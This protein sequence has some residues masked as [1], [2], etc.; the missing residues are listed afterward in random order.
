MKSD[1]N[2]GT[3]AKDQR[4]KLV[5]AFGATCTDEKIKHLQAIA[6]AKHYPILF[7]PFDYLNIVTTAL[8]NSG[9]YTGNGFQKKQMTEKSLGDLSKSECEDRLKR[10]CAYLNVEYAPERMFS[11]VEDGGFH[12][13]PEVWRAVAAN[14]EFLQECPPDVLK[15]IREPAKP[16]DKDKGPGAETA[17]VLSAVLGST[18]LMH[19]VEKA[20]KDIKAKNEGKIPPEYLEGMENT[21]LN[22]TNILDPTIDKSSSAKIPYRLN[23]TEEGLIP[24]PTLSDNSVPYAN[25]RYM[26]AAGGKH[27]TLP[28]T[29][30]DSKFLTGFQSRAIALEEIWNKLKTKIKSGYNFDRPKRNLPLHVRVLGDDQSAIRLPNETIKSKWESL[31]SPLAETADL[32]NPVTL[33]NGIQPLL[34]ASDA[35]IVMPTATSSNLADRFR[36]NFYLDSITV[37]KQTEPLCYQ[38]PV[39][40]VDDGSWSDALEFH[41]KLCEVGFCKDYVLPWKPSQLIGELDS[42][43]SFRANQYYHILDSAGLRPE[44]TTAAIRDWLTYHRK[45]KNE[46]ASLYANYDTKDQHFPPNALG[47][48]NGKNGHKDTETVDEKTFDIRTG[49]RHDPEHKILRMN[50]AVFCSASSMN[51]PLN[52]MTAQLTHDLVKEG[53]G[54]VYGGADQHMM[55]QI[56]EGVLNFRILNHLKLEGENR[57]DNEITQPFKDHYHMLLKDREDEEKKKK[58]DLHYQPDAAKAHLRDKEIESCKKI[59]DDDSLDYIAGVSTPYLVRKE[60]V[61]GTGPSFIEYF[62]VPDIFQRIAIMLQASDAFVIEP[63][64]PGTRQELDALLY[65][66]ALRHQSMWAISSNNDSSKHLDKP[67]IIINPEIGPGEVGTRKRFWDDKL[68]LIVGKE[69]AD[70]IRKNDIPRTGVPRH[71]GVDAMW[72]NVIM[73]NDEKEAKI[74]L[75][76][77]YKSFHAPQL[78]LAA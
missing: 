71:P 78:G 42:I 61:E 1:S 53:Y 19:Y 33:L 66:K 48:R 44:E 34:H 2:P 4:S 75:D 57:P 12:I 64:G 65:L 29:H 21:W 40:V 16:E 5:L 10:F 74:L 22:F 9:E 28:F 76:R 20:L 51:V 47:E 17:K 50:V 60:T 77:H 13:H 68:D 25:Y 31:K 43:Q 26:R 56:R 36:K 24:H 14:P 55:G 46:G 69:A 49:A 35:M 6:A 39:L 18:N 52:D 73:V 45:Q 70:I 27:G 41:E 67:I 63:G 37:A 32:L 38:K 62:E 59:L 30:P 15:K 54:I 7:L 23:M 8:E 3:P 11:F 72:A 58:E